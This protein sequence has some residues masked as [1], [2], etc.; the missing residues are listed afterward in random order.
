V[1]NHECGAG[2][3]APEQTMCRLL[4]KRSQTLRVRPFAR[5]SIHSPQRYVA[6]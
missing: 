1:G 2:A 5:A 4:V 3:C 6:R